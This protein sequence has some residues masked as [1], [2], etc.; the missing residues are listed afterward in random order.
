MKQTKVNKDTAKSLMEKLD[1]IYRVSISDITRQK[2][3]DIG[4][5]TSKPSRLPIEVSKN[6]S[7]TILRID[8]YDTMSEEIYKYLTDSSYTHSFSNDIISLIEL[9]KK[10]QSLYKSYC[11]A[12]TECSKSFRVVFNDNL[13]NTTL[14][15]N[16][17]TFQNGH[18]LSLDEYK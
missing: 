8:N 5:V 7:I 3:W 12:M 6:G 16:T 2:M 11:K 9:Y 14:K 17:F 15:I 1:E 13:D 4:L 18:S 10:V